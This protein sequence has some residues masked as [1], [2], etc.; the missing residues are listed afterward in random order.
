MLVVA[1]AFS[2]VSGRNFWEA[3]AW[4]LFSPV[5]LALFLGVGA[6]NIYFWVVCHQASDGPAG[7]LGVVCAA[8]IGFLLIATYYVLF[9][10]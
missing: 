4:V 1:G 5:V 8:I 9:L 7:V 10:F 6:L 3:L 2:A